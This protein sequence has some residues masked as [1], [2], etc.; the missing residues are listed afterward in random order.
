MAGA[1][2]RRFNFS[3]GTNQN[4]VNML[5]QQDTPLFERNL[6]G[7]GYNSILGGM[8]GGMNNGGSLLNS[9]GYNGQGICI[10]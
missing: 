7:N 4:T 3:R 2:G 5:A 10:S 8:N 1:T 6:I 9:N